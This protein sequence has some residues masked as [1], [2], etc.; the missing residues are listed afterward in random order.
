M[1]ESKQQTIYA[2]D[3]NNNKI[4]VIPKDAKSP[5]SIDIQYRPMRGILM[6]DEDYL[7]VGCDYG[8][9]MIFSLE[10]PLSP[11]CI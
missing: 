6:N 9:L 8:Y 10:T 11:V 7:I 2:G 3:T 5:T 1:C 4:F